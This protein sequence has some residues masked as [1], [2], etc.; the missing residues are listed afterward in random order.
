MKYEA[1]GITCQEIKDF[2]EFIIHTP[3]IYPITNLR[4]LIWCQF[5]STSLFEKIKNY[6]L[7]SNFNAIPW[8][9]I[10]HTNPYQA[11]KTIFCILITDSIYNSEQDIDAIHYLLKNG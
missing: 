9:Y 4:H 7:Y 11:L 8:E 1:L 6:T 10:V 3:I 5:F 2:E